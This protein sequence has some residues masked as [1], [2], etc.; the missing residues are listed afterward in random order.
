MV[1]KEWEELEEMSL[2]FVMRNEGD[3]RGENLLRECDEVPKV[4]L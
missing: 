1:H 2:A 3:V 4:A